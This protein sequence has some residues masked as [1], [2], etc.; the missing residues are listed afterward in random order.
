MK[1]QTFQSY[2]DFVSTLKNEPIPYPQLESFSKKI[3]SSKENRPLLFR[4]KS[5]P[6]SILLLS[7]GIFVFS[8][9]TV[10]ALYTK[11]L[12]HNKD[13]EI[14]LE[15]S[16]TSKEQTEKD[17]K[18]REIQNKWSY[19]IREIENSLLASEVSYLIITESYELDKI[20]YP[21]QQKQPF[22]NV[23]QMRS[24]TSTSFIAPAT[25]PASYKFSSGTILFEPEPIDTEKLYQEAKA[26]DMPYIVQ[27]GVL[28]NKAQTINLT[29]KAGD[30]K[31]N[32]P[33]IQVLIR[34]IPGG[35][36]GYTSTSRSINSMEVIKL[37]DS[38]L[39]YDQDFNYLNFIVE[40]NGSNL[41]YE[42]VGN[43]LATK[44]DLILIA[45]GLIT[46]P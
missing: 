40:H 26:S 20:Y 16:Q 27:K 31:Y 23:E 6:L 46:S 29:Y 13:G 34:E 43:D 33:E 3:T 15:Y 9:A 36:V 24:A 17:T 1:K 22:S 28:T 32:N 41:N 42:I 18:A 44:E 35:S 45:K 8:G 7:I 10:A 4:L 12:V 14:A 19:K 2:N 37:K 11:L 21:I 39:L 30:N 25:M 5:I 38:E